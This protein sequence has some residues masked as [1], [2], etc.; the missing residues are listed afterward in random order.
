MAWLRVGR[1]IRQLLSD[2]F[3][4]ATAGT[5]PDGADAHVP[6]IREGETLWAGLAIPVIME[7]DERA[8]KGWPSA[9]SR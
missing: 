9:C 1:R 5:R 6:V 2:G 3:F 7:G 8:N 4:P